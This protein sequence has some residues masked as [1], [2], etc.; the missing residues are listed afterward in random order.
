[1]KRYKTTY[2]ESAEKAGLKILAKF[3]PE[4]S[5][6]LKRELSFEQW[7]SVKRLLTDV[8]G[9]H[10]VGSENTLCN[11]LKE[12]CQHEYE[13]GTFLSEK[14]NKVTFVMVTDLK[15]VVLDTIFS[16]NRV[17]E[18]RDIGNTDVHTVQL[19]FCADKGSSQTKLLFIVLNS[20][21]QHSLN[22]AK[23]LA[24]FEGEKDTRECVEMVSID[25]VL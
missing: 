2:S 1:M 19:L 25:D 16:L 10:I 4:Q 22:R 6:S 18:L 13:T 14:G 3:T 9:R 15:S 11:F 5:A 8:A 20:K 24:I 7:R 17:N 21:L 12:T 23:L